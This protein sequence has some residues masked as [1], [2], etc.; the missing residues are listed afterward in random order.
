MKQALL[1]RRVR[2]ER[3]RK[4]LLLAKMALDLGWEE[5][6]LS[7]I[8][9]GKTELPESD[10]R[11]IAAY[12][13]VDPFLFGITES[14]DGYR[15]P[16]RFWD[17]LQFERWKRH[18]GRFRRNW[19]EMHQFNRECRGSARK[20]LWEDELFH[21]SNIKIDHPRLFLRVLG[22]LA[23]AVLLGDLSAD[24]AVTALSFGILVP[25]VLLWFLFERNPDR[26]EKVSGFW[27]LNLFL[28]GGLLSICF[29]LFVRA[30]IGYPGVPFLG[31]LITGLLEETAKI[32]IVAFLCSRFRISKVSTGILVGFAVGAGFA[33]IENARYG[34]DT[35]IATED[36]TFLEME[37][38]L[39]LRSFFGL[40]GAS[41]PFWTGMM[42]GSLISLSPSGHFEMK[43]LVKPVFLEWFGICVL[44]HALFN[45]VASLPWG[46]IW[47]I[48]LGILSLTLFLAMWKK[49]N[50]VEMSAPVETMPDECPVP[51]PET[52]EKEDFSPVSS[53]SPK[54]DSPSSGDALSFHEPVPVPSAFPAETVENTDVSSE[55]SQDGSDSRVLGSQ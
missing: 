9:S 25:M 14:L 2:R 55:T 8:E 21:P 29:V 15:A 47:G 18:P 48:L 26:S 44:L 49:A 7:D 46:L 41:H 32:L 23:L 30:W 20:Q 50:S 27:I 10:V 33:G 16:T 5:S 22:L 45:F 51:I 35:L 53:F 28:F 13:D 42:A 6:I 3:K 36:S 12:L 24:V 11:R 43:N 38:L 40:I 31:D 34:I 54:E 39:A 52:S 19:K 17:L 1:G 37:V 4:R